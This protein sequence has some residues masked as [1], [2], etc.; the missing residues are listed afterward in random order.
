M[1]YANFT[2]TAAAAEGMSNASVRLCGLMHRLC[3]QCRPTNLRL[4]IS[5]R[6]P[7]IC[8]SLAPNVLPRVL[9]SIHDC[10]RSRDC[11][12][13]TVLAL[14]LVGAARP[15]H[16]DPIV[17]TPRKIVQSA[18]TMGLKGLDTCLS[19]GE[20]RPCWLH[21]QQA[22]GHRPEIRCRAA[23]AM[24]GRHTRPTRRRTRASARARACERHVLTPTCKRAG[25]STHRHNS[26]AWTES[27]SGMAA[28]QVATRQGPG[29]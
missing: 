2:A 26:N 12:A 29:A 25:E 24:Q 9:T 15:G 7:H 8:T 22:E 17:R 18:T 16:L 3:D 19:H 14:P 4:I 21:G 13:P 11:H 1:R 10:S 27:L 6:I 23:S 20:H 5:H 28:T